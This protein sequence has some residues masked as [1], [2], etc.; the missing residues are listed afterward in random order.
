ML[1]LLLWLFQ[2]LSITYGENPQLIVV[3]MI[4][5]VIALG[6]IVHWNGLVVDS[7]LRDGWVVEKGL[8]ELHFGYNDLLYLWCLI[9]VAWACKY[10]PLRPTNGGWL[11]L[12]TE[13][14]VSY[15]VPTIVKEGKPSWG[16]S[17]STSTKVASNPTA[18]PE[19]ILASIILV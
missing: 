19:V 16:I 5:L 14:K 12:K 4:I 10:Y 17:T 7:M 11:Y 9:D 15:W 2:Y 3:N 6:F 13:A 18:A 8:M 1:Y